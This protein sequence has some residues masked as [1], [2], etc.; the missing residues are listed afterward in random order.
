MTIKQRLTDLM[1]EPDQLL[2]LAA[3]FVLHLFVAI[4]ILTV[5]QLLAGKKFVYYSS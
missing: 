3:P 5:V 1:Q 2:D 4:L